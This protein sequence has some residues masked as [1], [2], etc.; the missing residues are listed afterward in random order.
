MSGL[1]VNYVHQSFGDYTA[2][3]SAALKQLVPLRVTCIVSGSEQLGLTDSASEVLRCR[4]FRHPLS[5][6]SANQAVSSLSDCDV[7]HWQAA[8]NPWVD[9]AALRIAPRQP[10]VVT[11]H[12]MMPHPGDRSVLPGTFPAIRR[13]VHKA[14]QVI[15]HAESVKQ[16]VL[17]TGVDDSV[18]NVLAHGELGSIYRNEHQNTKRVS[19]NTVLFFGRMQHYKGLRVLLEAM[20][21]VVARRPESNLVLAG[22]GPALDQ[23]QMDVEQTKWIDVRHRYVPSEEVHDLFATAAVVALPYLEASQSGVA[24]LAVG[25][26]KATVASAVG[27]LVEM[28]DPYRNGLLVPS[29][30]ADALA[31][32][33]LRILDDSRLRQSL[34]QGARQRARTDLSWPRIAGQTVNVYRRAFESWERKSTRGYY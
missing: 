27:G 11:V 33:L 26:G 4:R 3:L 1:H 18:V 17:E 9:A 6:W 21:Q 34:E 23:L 5:G 32:A 2:G 16:Q 22:Q 10:F 30:S 12:D 19:P 14:D 25:M 28:V 29:D 20:N 31:E 7:L 15:V 13:L 8:G 24:A